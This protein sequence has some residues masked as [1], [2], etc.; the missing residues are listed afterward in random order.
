MSTLDTR[1]VCCLLS[2]RAALGALQFTYS[3]ASLQYSLGVEAQPKAQLADL[4]GSPSRHLLV[5]SCL[6]HL[7]IQASPSGQIV[8]SSCQV[9]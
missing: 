4:T 5:L 9:R 6:Q 7:E 2:W 3:F 1:R 8:Q